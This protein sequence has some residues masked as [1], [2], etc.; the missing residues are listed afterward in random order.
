MTANE[1][2]EQVLASPSASFWLKNA[3]RAALHRDCVQAT[4]DAELLAEL[5]RARLSQMQGLRVASRAE[6]LVRKEML[7]PSPQYAF[8]IVEDDREE[9]ER[10]AAM[11]K[12]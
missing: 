6:H 11:R 8:A 9:A 12:P 2:I 7:R 10:A 4:H 5:L 1:K 3:L